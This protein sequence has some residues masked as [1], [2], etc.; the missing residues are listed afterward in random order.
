MPIPALIAAGAAIAGSVI[1]AAANSN[2]ADKQLAANKE[3]WEMNNAYN[4]PENQVKRLRQAG[5]NP[6]LAMAN[7]MLGSGNSSSPASSYERP[8]YDF[9]PMSEGISKS[10]QLF[11]EKR[12]QDAQIDKMNQEAENQRLRNITQLARDN[13]EIDKM[14]SD[15][16]VSKQTKEVLETQ[17]RMNLINMETL[18]RENNARIDKIV[19]ERRLNDEKTRH[20]RLLADYQEL[21]N[22]YAPKEREKT[23]RI[24]DA[25]Y[26]SIMAA[27]SA[28]NSQAAYNVALKSL[29]E[30]QEKGVNIDNAQKPRLAKAIADKAIQEVYNISDENERAW[31]RDYYVYQGKV[32]QYFNMPSG[33]YVSAE[34]YQRSVNRNRFRK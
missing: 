28:S 14:L 25:N 2:S 7:G 26:K 12:V 15:S 17:K 18:G 22:S 3:L 8:T 19:S 33:Q 30:A 10:V 34:G 1:G 5:I 4:T 32:G 11:Q 6:Q 29:T 27:A 20:E 13:A 23:M 31:L 16:S 9:S 21:M 24:L